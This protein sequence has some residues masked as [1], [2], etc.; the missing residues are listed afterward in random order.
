MDEIRKVDLNLATREELEALPGIGEVLASRIIAARPFKTVDDLAKV[1]GI[2]PSVLERLRPYLTVT[3]METTA[4][5]EASTAIA[6]AA[7]KDQVSP[8]EAEDEATEAEVEASE[9]EEAPAG[10][11]EALEAA[12]VAL[13]EAAAAEAD[14]QEAEAE[15]EAVVEAQSEAEEAETEAQAET[16]EAAEEAEAQEEAEDAAPSEVA[17]PV[18]EKRTC[19][20]R[21]EAWGIALTTGLV[22]FLLAFLLSLGVLHAIN[23]GLRYADA[24]RYQATAREVQVLQDDLNQAQQSLD[25]LQR[26]IADLKSM[27]D[28]I[29]QLSQEQDALQSQVDEM[30]DAIEQV[31]ASAEKFENF[32]QG[33]TDL[34]NDMVSPA[35]T[36]SVTPTETPTP[37]PSP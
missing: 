15:A 23:G 14:A 31:Q 36:E 12:A 34:L 32:L 19:I 4:N 7:P 16:K 18:S 29:Q 24:T 30:A 25:T 22:A 37:T 13:A 21:R 2:R 5:E 26:Q 6:L 27:S 10:E 17:T 35:A 9:A 3:P 28:D 20:S 8:S 11:E 33:L 1:E